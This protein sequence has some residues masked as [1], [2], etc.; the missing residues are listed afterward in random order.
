MEVRGLEGEIEYKIT[1]EMFF[2]CLN[3]VIITG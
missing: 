2:K 1:K 3:Y